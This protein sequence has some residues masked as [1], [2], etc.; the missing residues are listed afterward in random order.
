MAPTAGGRTITILVDGDPLEVPA[1]LSLAAALRSSGITWWN[2]NPV[3]GEPRG[4]FCGMGVCWEC[5]ATVDGQPW[6]RACLAA[7][8]PGLRLDRPGG[9]P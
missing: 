9:P 6:V 8:T 7:A 2:S 1:G 3:T 5:R 4:A